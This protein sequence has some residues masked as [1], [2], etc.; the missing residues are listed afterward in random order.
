MD[1]LWSPWRYRYV[2]QADKD[3]ICIFC[4]ALGRK[5]DTETLILFRGRHNFIMLNRYPYTTGHA[6]VAPYEHV[7]ELSRAHPQTLAEMMELCQRLECAYAELYKPEGYN[8]GMNVGRI[9]GAGVTGHL[10]M[11]IL[12]RWAGDTSFMTTVAETRLEPEDLA[13][14]YA[15][16]KPY[17]EGRG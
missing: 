17:F 1:Y 3:N 13:T 2:S 7:A 4:E 12:P 11:H 14:T 8:L 16:L 9:A 10:H 15:K 6:M 5:Q